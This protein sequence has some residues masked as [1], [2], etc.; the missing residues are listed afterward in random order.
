MLREDLNADGEVDMKDTV[1]AAIAFGSYPGHP[2]WNPIADV[3]QDN[4]VDMRDIATI[5]RNI[6]EAV[7]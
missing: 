4:K 1:I 5:A 3:N 6:R 7:P 2:R